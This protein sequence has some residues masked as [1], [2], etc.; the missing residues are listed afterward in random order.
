[1][2]VK[3][4]TRR[5]QGKAIETV[6]E[7]LNP[8][9]RGWYQYFKHIRNSKYVF[10]NL[11]GFIRRRLRSIL[12]KFQAKKGSHRMSDNFV[13]TNKLFQN[14]WL[15]CLLDAHEKNVTLTKGKL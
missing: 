7:E 5:S 8:T 15:F 11:D 10:S 9:L 13:Y 14:L 4:K 1:M 3:I 6:I 12:A 2:K